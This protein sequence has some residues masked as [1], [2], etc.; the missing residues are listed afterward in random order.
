[1]YAYGMLSILCYFWKISNIFANRTGLETLDDFFSAGQ[2]ST[3][4]G[5]M[6]MSAFQE[7]CVELGIPLAE[8][9]RNGPSNVHQNKLLINQN[10]QGVQQGDGMPD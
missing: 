9:K 7:L 8:D 10:R 3:N 6:L 2:D 5:Q 4:D 1:M